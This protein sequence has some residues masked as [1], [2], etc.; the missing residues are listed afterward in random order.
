LGGWAGVAERHFSGYFCGAKI[1][2]ILKSGENGKK[3]CEN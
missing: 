1:E 3:S 2:N